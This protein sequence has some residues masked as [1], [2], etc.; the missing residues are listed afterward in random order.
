MS[1]KPNKAYYNHVL[2]GLAHKDSYCSSQER[3]LT[4]NVRVCIFSTGILLIYKKS[5]DECG[6]VMSMELL[7]KF[8]NLLPRPALITIYKAFIRNHSDYGGITKSWNPFRIIPSYVTRNAD[9]IPLFN[10]IRYNFYKNSFFPSTIIESNNLDSNLQNSENFIILKNN[11]LKLI[12]PK[13]NT[14]F[15]C[16]KLKEIRLIICYFLLHKPF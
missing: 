2:W 4:D 5:F 6:F 3:Q 12:R 10:S 9:D 15:N 11:I 13:P 16:S 7:R 14:F 8:Q 1:S